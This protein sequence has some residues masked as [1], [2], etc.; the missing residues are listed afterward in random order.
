MSDKAKNQEKPSWK[1]LDLYLSGSSNIFGENRILKL[2]LLVVAFATIVNSVT[3]QSARDRE[4]TI[5]VPFGQVANLHIVGDEPSQEYLAMIAKRIV[6]LTGTYTA[7]NAGLQ[8]EEVMKLI[9]PTEH[10][11]MRVAFREIIKQLQRR[12]TLSMAS[13][14]RI[15]KPTLVTDSRISVPIRRIR[16]IG[17]TP[18]QFLL[19]VHIDYLV[20]E[21]R[22]WVTNI[23]ESSD[24]QEEGDENA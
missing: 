6:N 20:E 19:T 14:P 21:G 8:F 1:P 11:R 16:I 22:F 4:R 12:S 23:T 3:L 17:Q 18:R 9:H 13:Y 7:S 15:E 5:I 10:E 2:V 24:E